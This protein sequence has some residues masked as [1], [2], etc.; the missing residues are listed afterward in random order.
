MATVSPGTPVRREQGT[1]TFA[2]RAVPFADLD[3]MFR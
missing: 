3:A 2:R 1:F